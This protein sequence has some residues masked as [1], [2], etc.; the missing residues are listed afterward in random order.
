M[1]KLYPALLMAISAIQGFSQAQRV[2]GTPQ[3]HQHLLSIDPAYAANRILLDKEVVP[4]SGTQNSSALVTIPVVFHVIYANAAENISDNRLFDQLNVL[5][6]D[7]LAQIQMRVILLP[8]LLLWV[9]YQ[10]TFCL[11]KRD[12]N[13]NATTV[14]LE[15]ALPYPLYKI[16]PIILLLPGTLPSI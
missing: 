1:K 6:A 15:Q 9:K 10:Y 13:G 11:A 5:N 4:N 3:L 8:L 12:P 16:S 14:L 2:C 7:F